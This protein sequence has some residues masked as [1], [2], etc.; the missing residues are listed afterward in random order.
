MTIFRLYKEIFI[1]S[2]NWNIAVFQFCSPIQQRQLFIHIGP[3]SSVAPANLSLRSMVCSRPG[4]PVHHL[5]PEPAQT[6]VRRVRDAMQ[7]SHP[8]SSP[9][10]LIFSLSQHQGLSQWVSS[11]HQVAKVSELQ[12]FR[13]RNHVLPM[14]IEDWFL[15]GWNGVIFL[16]SKALSRVFSNTTVQKHQFFGTQLSIC[17]NSHI[18]TWYW[19][20]YSFD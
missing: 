8:L 13:T 5:L 17:S 18:H 15:L 11:L 10:P 3:F 20:N 4:F 19:K 2:S 14:N 1:K 6:H 12:N 7:P 16:Q 9:S